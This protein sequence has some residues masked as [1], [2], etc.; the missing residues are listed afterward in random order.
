ME[1]YATMRNTHQKLSEM[2]QAVSLPSSDELTIM[3]VAKLSPDQL[4]ELCTVNSVR[5]ANHKSSRGEFLISH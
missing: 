4:L 1:L 5:G 3:N 2:G